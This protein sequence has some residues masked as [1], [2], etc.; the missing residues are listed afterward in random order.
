M[1]NKKKATSKVETDTTSREEVKDVETKVI[2]SE[3]KVKKEF[4]DSDY[5]LCRSVWSG[6]LNITCKSGA[7][8]EFKKY[9]AECDIE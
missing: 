1:A 4:K 7:T 5:V 6:G 2:E 9:G 8:Y 3:V